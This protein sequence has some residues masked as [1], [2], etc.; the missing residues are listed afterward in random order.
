MPI[1][2]KMREMKEVKTLVKMN[3][4]MFF[5]FL[6]SFCLLVIPPFSRH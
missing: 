2:M 5:F 3:T 4:L 6:Y 1:M